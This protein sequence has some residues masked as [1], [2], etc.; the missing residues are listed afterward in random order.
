MKNKISII[1][2]YL[3]KYKPCIKELEKRCRCI[4]FRTLIIIYY[5]NFCQQQYILTMFREKSIKI[6]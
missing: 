2:Q 6:L 4:K 1:T 5:S 3:Y